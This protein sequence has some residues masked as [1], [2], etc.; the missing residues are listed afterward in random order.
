MKKEDTLVL[1]SIR[2]NWHYVIWY[3]NFTV[4]LV[5]LVIPFSLLAYWNFNT[6]A[7]MSRRRRLRNRPTIPESNYETIAAALLNVHNISPSSGTR[8]ISRVGK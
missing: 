5:S 7:V 2:L 1:N 8:L 4:L 3:K 6:L